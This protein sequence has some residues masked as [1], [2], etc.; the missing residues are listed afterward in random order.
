M[1]VVKRVLPIFLLF[2][3]VFGAFT[4]GSTTAEANY[5]EYGMPYNEP[6]ITDNSGYLIL[7]QNG[8]PVVYYWQLQ[9]NSNSASEGVNI[10]INSDS[11]V[12]S[13]NAGSNQFLLFRLNYNGDIDILNANYPSTY[14]GSI[15]YPNAWS[16]YGN[17]GAVYD[18]VFG[19]SHPSVSIIWNDDS[20]ILDKLLKLFNELAKLN[21]DLG[22]QLEGIYL[23]L[24]NVK[25]NT[26]T[27]VYYLDSIQQMINDLGIDTKLDIQIQ[28]QEEANELQKEQNTT[29]TNIFTSMS[30][31]F[32]S[33]FDN[34]INMVKS[35]VIP[36]DGYFESVFD[37]LY[38]FFAGKLG[39][40]LYP[41]Q[42]MSRLIE[43]YQGIETATVGDDAGVLHLPAVKIFDTE[44]IPA[45]DFDLKGL[46]TEVLGEYY[47]LYYAFV[48]VLI[49]C[50]F[51]GFLVKKYNQLVR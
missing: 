4:F 39:V 29:S 26:D 22:G 6:P 9:P 30:D 28:K 37:R 32:G 48:D 19:A 14:E 33:F 50:L 42:L 11:L 25:I 38:E 31:F 23:E 8:L 40:L 36:E 45:T 18:N 46:F 1:R 16:V 5:I 47:D 34:F 49:I 17:V 27:I 20:L 15:S 41:F 12:I 35:L 13:P 2:L 7:D 24:E 51:V 10:V 43:A 3:V 21:T 44:L